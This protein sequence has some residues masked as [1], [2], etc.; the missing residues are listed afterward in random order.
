MVG[1]H[2]YFT[3]YEALA[4]FHDCM[5]TP[6]RAGL[7]DDYRWPANV[8]Y[9]GE[10][11]TDEYSEIKERN[12]AV[13]SKTQYLKRIL[14]VMYRI[15]PVD[16]AGQSLV[17]IDQF[18]EC[19]AYV[20]AVYRCDEHAI[21]NSNAYYSGTLRQAQLAPGEF[22]RLLQ[23]GDLRPLARR[24][25]LSLSDTTQ[26][27]SDI[28]K[29]DAVY[30][31]GQSRASILKCKVVTP[32]Y[33]PHGDFHSPVNESNWQAWRAYLGARGTRKPEADARARRVGR[34]KATIDDYFGLAE[35]QSS[36]SQPKG[37]EVLPGAALLDDANF[38]QALTALMTLHDEREATDYAA[39]K[40]LL[41]SYVGAQENG[42]IQRRRGVEQQPCLRSVMLGYLKS[43]EVI[44][45]PSCYGCNRCVPELSSAELSFT[46]VSLEQRRQVIVKL[47]PRLMEALE[48]AELATQL[49]SESLLEGFWRAADQEHAEGRS[50]Y[51][52]ID[53]WTVRLLE[54]RTGHP[55]ALAIRSDAMLRG[56]IVLR[57]QELIS[58]LQ[59]LAPIC[60]P[61]K[62]PTLKRF[63]T[64]ALEQV[65]G[66]RSLHQLQ[67]SVARAL[68]DAPMEA[69]GWE[70]LVTLL[71]ASSDSTLGER[72]EAYGALSR[73][74][75][76]EGSLRDQRRGEPWALAA[77]ESSPDL[78]TALTYARLAVIE[79]TWERVEAEL[80]DRAPTSSP[81]LIEAMLRAWL[82]VDIPARSVTV[83]Q[84]L[85]GTPPQRVWWSA[86]ELAE[87]CL[88]LDERHLAGLP[89]LVRHTLLA[90][91][92][93]STQLR[94]AHALL[95][96][97]AAICD[98]LVPHL[99]VAAAGAAPLDEAMI[100]S[101]ADTPERRAVV[102]ELGSIRAATS[103]HFVWWMTQF[104][105]EVRQM[106]R[107]QRHA[108]LHHGVPLLS[109]KVDPALS[110]WLL[111][112]IADL[113][114]DP[115]QAEQAHEL[116]QQAA[117]LDP[118]LAAAY[119]RFC[120]DHPGELHRLVALL[121]SKAARSQQATWRQGVYAASRD[122]LK[123]LPGLEAAAP[124][125]QL[126]QREI[127][128][129]PAP[130][131][132]ALWQSWLAIP[133]QAQPT[134][135]LFEEAFAIFQV[136][137]ANPEVGSH[138]HTLWQQFVQ[139]VPSS[140]WSY[141]QYCLTLAGGSAIAS[142][143]LAWLATNMPDTCQSCYTR[144][145]ATL[146]HQL[147]KEQI[148]R[149]I[150]WFGPLIEYDR[151]MRL[152]LLQAVVAITVQ[153]G[154]LGAGRTAWLHSVAATLSTEGLISREKH[155]LLQ[156]EAVR[157]WKA[158]AM[159]SYIML[160]AL[161]PDGDAPLQDLLQTVK[162][163]TDDDRW[164]KIIYTT[165]R[166]AAY[167]TSWESLAQWIA[168]WAEAI[169]QDTIPGKQI[170]VRRGLE[171][172]QTAPDQEV[173]LRALTL[174][175]NDALNGPHVKKEDVSPWLPFARES[176]AALS[177][178]LQF[179]PTSL[180]EMRARST[181]I[182]EALGPD[183]PHQAS[184]YQVI[185]PL[186]ARLDWPALEPI[187]AHCQDLVAAERPAQRLVLLQAALN[188]L[189]KVWQPDQEPKALE[190]V[191]NLTA[192]LLGEQETSGQAAQI[193]RALIT[194]YAVHIPLLLRIL[195]EH[196]ATV[197]LEQALG[198]LLGRRQ[199][200]LIAEL[201]A[202]P[203]SPRWQRARMMVCALKQLLQLGLPG[204]KPLPDGYIETLENLLEPWA[205]PE[206][207]DMVA[208]ALAQIR[209]WTTPSFLTP[210]SRQVR[211][212]IAAGRIVAAGQ[213]AS[214]HADLTIGQHK[215]P[216]EVFLRTVS[217][218]PNDER[219]VNPD[220]AQIATQMFGVG[221][222]RMV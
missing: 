220:Y 93:T 119:A 217:V 163:K 139:A 103:A 61:A 2:L 111:Q 158:E 9:E 12:R 187:L 171:L 95:R 172:V 79:W 98:D 84:F 142:R 29:R 115:E 126:F 152:H 77:T 218:E 157:L 124:W 67:V 73:L 66:Q 192:R 19:P 102:L 131:Q 80:A 214:T 45:G 43:Y 151:P 200:H 130:E 83:A 101:L 20:D 203:A 221:P 127:I 37:W 105:T 44:S 91:E 28:K 87:L 1:S 76:G 65:Q 24:L 121:S 25:Q 212:L 207:A 206:Q 161:L 183:T 34:K 10:P 39:Y 191:A 58:L 146:T 147:S 69:A 110:Q 156:W 53:G 46:S 75:L 5:T 154:N 166:T 38:E 7:H 71:E 104:S 6:Q 3:S 41:T 144:F 92:E 169:A 190:L 18:R 132:L 143:Y 78:P 149:A 16:S 201:P 117:L 168:T 82:Q 133:S 33:G 49:P 74:Y 179:R 36:I 120:W 17:F 128:D 35:V 129:E 135:A 136:L 160:C 186:W 123:L 216:I 47:G 189:Q 175:A 164:I 23:A 22:T 31:N 114:A 153:E 14:D 15:R 118:A 51:S 56:A 209:T 4:F 63:I 81:M 59:G 85:E 193:W 178:Y 140:A 30:R 107:A 174:L 99:V 219:P 27:L 194:S 40:R 188:Q 113:V 137:L 86:A 125:L 94:L 13:K 141:L 181:V 68:G 184:A 60:P 134:A 195:Q 52:Y 100:L 173:A 182:R 176:A 50:A 89:S 138:A 96:S 210:L 106:E 8:G 145:Q 222:R 162:G 57:A 62:L 159:V 70:A 211:A 177:V 148:T 167:H 215:Q 97:G 109:T 198:T 180:D 112:Q 202:Y 199:I 196:E 21:R 213:L 32:L 72:H 42:S 185:R 108:L 205:D 122:A 208:A 197:E 54:E 88:T 204:T 155:A 55:A 11:I 116:W 90:V 26:L 150:S 170:I 165:V 48:S 64:L